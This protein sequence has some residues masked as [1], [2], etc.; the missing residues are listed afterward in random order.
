M[1]AM[2]LAA[3]LGTRLKP[4]TDYTPKA[5]VKLNGMTLLEIAIRKLIDNN[6]RKIIINVHHFAGQIK[7]FLETNTFAADIIIS[8]ESN[9][10]L[11]TGGGIKFAKKY[12][13]NTPVLIHNVDIISDLDLKDF[14]QYHISDDAIASLCVSKRTSNRYLLFNN[15]NVL[16]GWQ[17]VKK[18][19]KIIVRNEPDLEQFAFNGIQVLS[20]EI[21]NLFPDENVFSV[22]KA[23]LKIAEND[24][25]NAFIANDINWI[26]VGK[27]DSLMKAEELIKN[28]HLI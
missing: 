24:D 21:I 20:P 3:G 28:L 22:I 6:F 19:E 9:L 15:E 13:D 8:D 27:T 25:I 12:F 23:Y 7:E 10:L 16:C 5:L 1:Q 4:V 11:D 26:D 17:D 18:E 2:I 14:Y